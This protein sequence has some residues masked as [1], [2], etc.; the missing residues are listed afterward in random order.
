MTALIRD[1]GVKEIWRI[2]GIA[3]A[4]T[5]VHAMTSVCQTV[6]YMAVQLRMEQQ[7]GRLLRKYA[8]EK[9]SGPFR[10]IGTGRRIL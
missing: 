4:P 2:D 10:R 9:E 3:A 6:N 5:R 8:G 7:L 1:V